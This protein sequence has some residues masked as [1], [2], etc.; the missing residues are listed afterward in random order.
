M[1]E[2][3]T[4]L[5]VH[6]SPPSVQR[7]VFLVL[8]PRPAPSPPREPQIG[9]VLD[10]VLVLAITGLTL[11]GVVPPVV[12]VALVGPM[13]GARIAALKGL[14]LGAMLLVIFGMF[15]RRGT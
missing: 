14:G 7:R 11:A 13:I 10:I 9:M 1:E 5:S 3:K 2:S 6:S 12:F 8:A 15:G 4:L